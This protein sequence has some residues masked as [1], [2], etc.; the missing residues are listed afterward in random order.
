MTDSAAPKQ[1]PRLTSLSHGGG[2]GCKIAPGVLSDILKHT[3]AMPMPPELMVGIET[4]DD[5]AVYRLNDEQAL[6]A[7]TDF[8]MPIVDDAFD[9]GRIA[10]TNAI[11][12]VYA[13]GGRPILA[14]ALVG[15]PINVLST[16]TIGRIL[17]GG[18]AVCRDAGIV[19]AGGHTIDSVEAIYGLVALGIAHPDR[20]RRNAD[21]QPGDVLVL[22][23]PLGVGVMSAALK[24][25]ALDDAG[26]ARMI[27]STTK[28]NVAGPDLAA[29]DGVHAMTDVTGFGLA[30]HGLEIARGS[31]CDVLID[32]ASVPLHAGVRALATQS[33][34][35]G[36]SGRN[37]AGYGERVLLPQDFAAEDRALLTDP[38]TSGGLLVS[39]AP[40]SLDA[41]LAAFRRHGFDAAAVVGRVGD[42]SERPVLRVS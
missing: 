36:A 35:T 16:A 38:Q 23:K 40:S 28:L 27:A 11:S 20:I 6:I 14:L 1:E 29:L 34:V 26:Y 12:D 3:A 33:F 5:A 19:V 13:M 32:W 2:C 4:S 25:G 22:G 37:W 41:V 9:F 17:E 30:G 31:G 15:M 10:A 24:K 42:R 21:A 39:C 8:F 18:A 7:T